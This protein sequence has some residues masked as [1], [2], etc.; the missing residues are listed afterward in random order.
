M[1]FKLLLAD[2]HEETL[3][4][5]AGGF[6]KVRALYRERYYSTE[7]NKQYYQEL[8]NDYI[9]GEDSVEKDYRTIDQNSFRGVFESAL[10]ALDGYED[11]LNEAQGIMEMIEQFRKNGGKVDPRKK[12]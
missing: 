2:I 7:E 9:P 3:L 8:A 10:V 4:G 12:I 11:R 6:K 5:K 1:I